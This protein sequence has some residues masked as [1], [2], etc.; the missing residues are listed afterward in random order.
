MTYIFRNNFEH[1]FKVP[2]Y[3]DGLLGREVGNHQNRKLAA[4]SKIRCI[5]FSNQPP[6]PHYLS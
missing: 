6:G 1:S 4:T 5:E 3:C 2:K